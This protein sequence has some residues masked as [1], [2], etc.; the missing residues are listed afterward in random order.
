[1]SEKE[2]IKIFKPNEIDKETNLYIEDGIS[3]GFPSPASDFEESRISIE[4]VV[5]KNKE[6]TFYA[7]VS[8][9]SMKDAGLNDGDILVIDRSE[10]LKNNKIAVCY[11]NGDFTVKRVKI[12]KKAVYLIPENKNYKPIKV[13]EENEL[14]VWGIVT[15]VIKKV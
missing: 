2:V 9:D 6:S 13:T 5:I 12:E 11:L 3:A 10:E 1:M 15:Y 7:K 14:I 4:K 8:G